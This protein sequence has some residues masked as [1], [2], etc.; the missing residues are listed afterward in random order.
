MTTNPKNEGPQICR[1]RGTR[2]SAYSHPCLSYLR[3]LQE[4]AAAAA[5]NNPQQ[6]QPQ[7]HLHRS[8]SPPDM[9]IP[10]SPISA[11]SP[12]Q[13]IVSPTIGSK[14]PSSFLEASSLNSMPSISSVPIPP[15]RYPIAADTYHNHYPQQNGVQGSSYNG[16]R[17]SESNGHNMLHQHTPKVEEQSPY[18]S[19]PSDSFS[20]YPLYNWSYKQH[21]ALPLPPPTTVPPL[22]YYYRPRRLEEIAPRDTISLIIALFFDFV[23]PLTPCIHK[24]S[25]MADLHSHR[26]ER[27][28]LFFALVMSTVASTLVQVPRSYLPMERPVVRKLAQVCYISPFRFI[29]LS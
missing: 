9:E 23:Y 18:P 4:A 3:R 11:L 16:P 27:D 10:A 13:S 26:E 25:F 14:S 19:S 2:S 17:S 8:G 6:Q 12:P 20:T 22:S 24:P 5:N 1:Y 15:S 21:Q 7:H 28:P 29:E